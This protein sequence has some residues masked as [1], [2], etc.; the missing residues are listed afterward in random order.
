MSQH[1]VAWTDTYLPMVTGISYTV[2]LWREHWSDRHDRMDVVFPA[3]DG[4]APGDGEYPVRSVR[5][6]LYP[7]YRLGLPSTPNDLSIPDVVHLHTP[8]TVGVAGLRFARRHDLPTV[9][10]YHTLLTERPEHI[11]DSR[12][13]VRLAT[14]LCRRYERWFYEAVDLVITPTAITKRFLLDEVGL[15]TEVA[16]LSN[17]IDL[18]LFRPIDG[19][20][21]RRAHGL[22][23][24][25]RL[26]GYTGRHSPEKRIRDV[27]DAVEGMES[28]TLVLG[29]DGPENGALR[30]YAARSAADVRFLGL[31]ERERLA[32]FYSAIDVFVYPS[33]VESEGL[34]VLEA[35]ACG[36]PAVVPEAGALARTV[37]DG[38]TGYH[39][40]PGD[41]AGARAA[42]QRTFDDLDRLEDLCLR[43]REMLSVDHSLDHLE[44]LYH[45][46]CT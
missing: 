40:Q 18:D 10:S 21:F 44:R 16:V 37:I 28:V 34:A 2:A 19:R 33:P 5:A 25:G 12:W 38:E 46:L 14:E 42:L 45:R 11:F 8:F 35:N 4:Y 3:A 36:T 17:G 26:V 23:L 32:D 43:R 24:E 22:P 30:R 31:L 7:H 41:V 29:G 39:Y 15:E 13:G 9:A 1:V 20:S 27:I 6:P